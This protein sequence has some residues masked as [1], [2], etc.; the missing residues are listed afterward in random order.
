M[1]FCYTGHIELDSQTVVQMLA[2]AKKVE[3]KSLQTFCEN[4][5]EDG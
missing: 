4:F 2:V 5:L 1:T 3:S